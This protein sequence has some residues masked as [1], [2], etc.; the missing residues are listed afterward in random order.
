MMKNP[1]G[2]PGSPDRP[3]PIAIQHKMADAEW[4]RRY[5]ALALYGAALSSPFIWTLMQTLGGQQ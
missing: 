4:R 5:L 1:C 3:R 2:S